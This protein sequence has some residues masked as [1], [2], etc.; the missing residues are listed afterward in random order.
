M[1]DTN[2]LFFQLL[3]VSLGVKDSLSLIPSTKEWIN[4]YNQSKSQAVLGIAFYGIQQLYKTYPIICSNLPTKIRMQWLGITANIQKRNEIMNMHTQ[5]TIKLFSE[6]GFCC[7][8]LKGQGIARLYGDLGKLRQ[9]GDIDVWI[10]GPRERLYNFAKAMF[11]KIEGLTY[12]HIH[13]PAFTEVEVEA[14]SFPS[15]LSSPIRNNRL[16]QFCR[17]HKPK[18]GSEEIPSLAFNRVY[19]LLHCYQHFVRKGVGLRQFMDYYYVLNKG[20]SEAERNDTILWCQK[21]GMSR[22]M[23]A[24]MYVMKTGFGI[25]EK[26]LLCEADEKKGQFL[27][28]EVMRSGNMG[29]ADTRV[30]HGMPQTSIG[31]YICNLRRDM[32]IVRICPHEALWE[33]FWGIYQY[34]WCRITN[35]KYNR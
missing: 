33:P 12:H 6:N 23:R 11:G 16:R 5:S 14:H 13:F 7:Q 34:L 35:K 29:H 3:Q 1:I 24:T 27:L 22:F 32:A 2:N 19:I 17:L 26:Y 18:I 28:D 31:R 30:N 15:F 21:L 8:V 4:L 9:S 10:P 25:N 20:F